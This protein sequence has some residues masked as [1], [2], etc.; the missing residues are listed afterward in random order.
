MIIYTNQTNQMIKFLFLY[1]CFLLFTIVTTAQYENKKI[2]Y[3]N[4]NVNEKAFTVFE[5]DSTAAAVYLFEK[6]S[7]YF[8]VINNRVMLVKEYHTKIKIL[9]LRFKMSFPKMV[10]KKGLFYFF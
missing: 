9:K 10:K 5:N 2:E 1:F 7:N 3:G 4:I 6:G 8:E